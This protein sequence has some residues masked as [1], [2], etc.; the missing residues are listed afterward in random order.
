M[1]RQPATPDVLVLGAGIQGVCAAL[2]LAHNGHRV[3]LVDAAEDCMQR[4][5]MRNEGKIHLGF[6][7]ANDPSARTPEL[8]LEASLVFGDLLER[9]IGRV[10][11]W[12]RLRS[13][14]F[15]YLVLDDSIVPPDAIFDAYARLGRA[16]DARRPARYLGT[17]P[18][19]LWAEIDVAELGEAFTATRIVAAASTAEMAIDRVLLR[20]ELREVLQ[21]H[22]RITTRFGHTV[23]DATPLVSRVH[24]LWHAE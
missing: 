8:M 15:T 2:A 19:Q 1:A 16:Y 22:P 5:S 10:L 24:G 20:R 23:H 18:G 17:T 9:W 7:Y 14:P 3:V 12:N 13:R 21:A 6:V 11:P 4:A